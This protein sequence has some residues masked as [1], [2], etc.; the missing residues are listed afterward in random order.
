MS[1]NTLRLQLPYPDGEAQANLRDYVEAD[2][3]DP[4]P[5]FVGRE[6]IIERVARDVARCQRNTQSAACFTVAIHGA[7]GSGKTSLLDE[8]KKRLGGTEETIGAVTVVQLEG[9][10]L[11]DNAHVA[12]V[13][14]DEYR[15]RHSNAR[16]EKT[17]ACTKK[18]GFKET[19]LEH[20]TTTT[21]S[22]IEQQIRSRGSLWSAIQENT[23]IEDENAVYLLLVDEAQNISGGNPDQTGRNDIAI[24]LHAGFKATAGLK[25]VPV[26]AGLSDTLSVL[27]VRGISRIKGSSIQLG[28]LTQSETTELVTDWMRHDEFGFQN[29]FIASDINRVAKMITVASEGWPRHV[30]TYLRELGRSVLEQGVNDKIEVDLNGVFDRGHND[31]LRYYGDRMTAARLGRYREVIRDAARRSLDGVVTKESLSTIAEDEYELP[32]SKHESLHENAIHAGI[33][34]QAA[35]Q[36]YNQFKFPIPSLLTYMRCDGNEI[37]FKTAMRDHMDAHSHLWLEDRSIKGLT[38]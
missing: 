22:T 21:W 4:P 1:E 34:E 14:I 33:L 35:A 7:P 26:F 32:E 2:D 38:H 13:F 25:I 24:N 16:V 31:R 37:E 19:G 28:A 12:E 36:N 9:N 23:S 30:N 15:G 29:L 3:R 11:A 8:I 27:S 10:E 18:L 20:Q 6:T 5:I 17:T